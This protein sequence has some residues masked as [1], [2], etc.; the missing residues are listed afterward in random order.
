MSTTLVLPNVDESRCTGCGRCEELCPTGA[1]G[2]VA[3]RARVLRPDLCSFC[4]TC[5][6]YCP[7]E[8]ISRPFVVHF[9]GESG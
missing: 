2:I 3:G 4:P 6:T 7:T 5:E 8:A 1:V 9:A